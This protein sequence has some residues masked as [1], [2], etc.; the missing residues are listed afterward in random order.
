MSGGGISSIPS[1][2]SIFSLGKTKT[3]SNSNN[4]PK[5]E[6]KIANDSDP[7]DILIHA[8]EQLGNFLQSMKE[9]GEIK[10]FEQFNLQFEDN[11]TI[12]SITNSL[13]FEQKNINI[14]N[15]TYAENLKK[16][17]ATESNILTQ[18]K[19]LLLQLIPPE[20]QAK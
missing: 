15:Q 16:Y 19:E 9:K 3:S 18:Y 7:L 11:V 13:K 4:K 2:P 1:M 8:N 14:L 6:K 17:L 12:T 20:L 10:K 5:D